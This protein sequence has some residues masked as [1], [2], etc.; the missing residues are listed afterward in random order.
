MRLDLAIAAS[1]VL[2]GGLRHDAHGALVALSRDLLAHGR[3]LA[4][5]ATLAGGAAGLAV[6]HAVLDEIFPEQGHGAAARAA[7]ERAAR[8]VATRPLPLSLYSGAVGV[9]WAWQLVAGGA[10][11]AGLCDAVDGLVL[12]AVEAGEARREDLTDGLCGL[13]VYAFERLPRAEARRA[14]EAIVAAL[15]RLAV[16]A[17]RGLVWP[18]RLVNLAP[19]VRRYHVDGE[20]DTGLAHGAAGILV[21]TARAA[22]EGVA[23]AQAERVARGAATWLLAQRRAPGAPTCFPARVYPDRPPELPVRPGW[24]YGDL[25]PAT[26]LALAGRWLGEPRWE[27]VALD[28]ARAVAAAD[29]ATQGCLDA[30]LCHGAAGVGHM[31]HRLFLRTGDETV[32]RAASAWMA[33]ALAGRDAGAGPGG[34]GAV[35]LDALGRA[36]T[37]RDAGLL[38]GAGGVALALASALGAPAGWDRMLALS[39]GEP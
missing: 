11:D 17:E 16:P 31:L 25:G 3:A 24:C 4:Q 26:A 12:D 29:P 6:V 33:R 2:G 36:R 32:E 34:F 30:G 8:T 35:R 37:R 28:V 23:A 21:V 18:T 19:A 39:G 9:T 5:G 13:A 15:A 20:L 1:P 7:L 10:G 22:A 14:L 27:R 38:V